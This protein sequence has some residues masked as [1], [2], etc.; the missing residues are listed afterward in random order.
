[1]WEA[2]REALDALGKSGTVASPEIWQVMDKPPVPY[3]SNITDPGICGGCRERQR[4]AIAREVA[5]GLKLL[6]GGWTNV[7]AE[8]VGPVGR[9]GS[10]A[11]RE[12]R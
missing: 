9:A 1:V 7:D 2:Q 5:A 12:V 10:V 3:D 4:K 6:E 11:L 8:L